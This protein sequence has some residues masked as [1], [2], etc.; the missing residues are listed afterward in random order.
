MFGQYDFD[1]I[2]QD[3]S[4][5]HDMGGQ[6]ALNDLNRKLFNMFQAFPNED[7]AWQDMRKSEFGAKLFEELS[8]FDDFEF[9]GSALPS[10]EE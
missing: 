9:N 3:Y 5:P 10:E 1:S 8:Q 2:E 4:L 7:A 6:A